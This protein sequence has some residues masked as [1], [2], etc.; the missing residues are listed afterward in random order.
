[1]SYDTTFQLGDFYVSPLIFRHTLFKEIPYMPVMFLIHER[2]FMETHQ[3]MF[4]ECVKCIP[5]LKKVSCPLVTDR[6]KGIV[7]AIISAVK[8][9]F[10]W[11]HVFRDIQLWCR[12]HGAPKVDIAVYSD[13]LFE[14]FHSQ[15]EK[16]YS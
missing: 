5:S 13:D 11:N 3:E 7:N 8:L 6:E 12:K 15:S 2:T 4:K 14:L 10:C 16:E 1:M 9:I